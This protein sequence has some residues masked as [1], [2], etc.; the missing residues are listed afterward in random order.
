MFHSLMHM[1]SSQVI[2]L[3][4]AVRSYIQV[5]CISFDWMFWPFSTILLAILDD[6]WAIILKKNV[7]LPT[8]TT[9]LP[10]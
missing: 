8:S 1:Q 3:E 5:S 10:F 9:Y 6:F 4:Q 7:P 2:D